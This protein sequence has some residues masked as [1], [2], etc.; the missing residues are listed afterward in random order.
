MSKKLMMVK[1]KTL[2]RLYMFFNI[3]LLG[4]LNFLNEMASE[5]K[6]FLFP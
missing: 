3:C 4:S 2:M 6:V 1:Y 5:G